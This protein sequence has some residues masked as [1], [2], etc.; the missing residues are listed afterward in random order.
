MFD[1]PGLRD[2]IVS[3]INSL[4]PFD[5]LWQ[6]DMHSYYQSFVDQSPTIEEV[7]EKVEM[8]F[9]IEKDIASIPE[10]SIIGC[11]QLTMEPMKN[12][13]LALA[14]C[15]KFKF[16]TFLHDSAKMLLDEILE[17]HK[18]LREKLQ[19][20][21]NTLEDLRETIHLLHEVMDLEN[22]V[23]DHFLSVEKLYDFLK[24]QKIRLPRTE[25]QQVCMCIHT[26]VCI[27]TYIRVYVYTYIMYVYAV[28]IS[29]ASEL[30]IL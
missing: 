5:P 16:S 13:L 19:G 10:Q 8:Y 1:F 6:D 26:Y 30:I 11:I 17:R 23:D 15:W 18:V 25:I 9:A 2:R 3:H 22:L 21:V 7:T 27:Y 14:R 20:E 24:K 12:S 29:L 4:S 28:L